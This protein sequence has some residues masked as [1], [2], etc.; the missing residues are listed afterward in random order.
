MG[1]PL[2]FPSATLKYK[3]PCNIRT[4]REIFFGENIFFP[5]TRLTCVPISTVF[6]AVYG[7]TI[8]ILG[9]RRSL[10]VTIKSIVLLELVQRGYP[11]EH[12]VRDKY[13]V[14]WWLRAVSDDFCF[15]EGLWF[16]WFNL[17]GAV[18]GWVVAKW[19]ESAIYRRNNVETT[20]CNSVSWQKWWL[21]L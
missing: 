2:A 5:P 9:K 8:I 3:W 12:Y 17:G 13:S 18:D 21:Y 14:G 4:N 6:A 11:N 15:L 10:T 7:Q 19:V 16:V 20:L 1:N